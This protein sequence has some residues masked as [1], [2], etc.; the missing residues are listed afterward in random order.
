MKTQRTQ[1]EQTRF[2]PYKMQG[3]NLAVSQGGLLRRGGFSVETEPV[4]ESESI[5]Q[6]LWEES[7]KCPCHQIVR[8]AVRG[9][10]GRGWRLEDFGCYPYLKSQEVFQTGVRMLLLLLY[11][12]CDSGARGRPDLLE[13]G[14]LGGGWKTGKPEGVGGG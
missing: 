7:L 4:H 12:D 9:G 11:M 2:L 10:G 6:T 3:T 8:A 5:C 14:S 1:K 13:S